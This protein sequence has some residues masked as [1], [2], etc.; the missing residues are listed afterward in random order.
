MSIYSWK[1]KVNSK[2]T[3][4]APHEREYENKSVKGKR[5]VYELADESGEIDLIAFNE[6]A[7]RL[8]SIFNESQVRF[9]IISVIIFFY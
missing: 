3:T 4:R 5:C 6:N 2:L 1:I 9:I 8:E 7:K